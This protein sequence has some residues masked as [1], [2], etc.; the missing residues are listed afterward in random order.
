MFYILLE[1]CSF[2]I[3][4]LS[5]LIRQKL[6]FFKWLYIGPFLG[7]YI[8]S[9]QFT[10]DEIFDLKSFTSCEI[11]LFLGYVFKNNFIRNLQKNTLL[12]FK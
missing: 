4:L 9:L 1:V 5:W 11:G 7:I 8:E 2:S 10:V 12:F 3:I 6:I